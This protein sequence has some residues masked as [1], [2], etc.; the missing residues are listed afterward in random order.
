MILDLVSDTSLCERLMRLPRRSS[1]HCPSPCSSADTNCAASAWGAVG[2]QTL[3]S[4]SHDGLPAPAAPAAK[5]AVSAVS[6]VD[7]I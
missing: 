2:G 5:N 1:H 7:R 4:F 3:S 6:Y